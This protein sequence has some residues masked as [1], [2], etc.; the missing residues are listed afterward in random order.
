MN[1][2]LNDGKKPNKRYEK[3]TEKHHSESDCELINCLPEDV[4][5]HRSGKKIFDKLGRFIIKN[6]EF[7]NQNTN[8]EN[9]L[10]A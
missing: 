2:P 4:L 7:F 6:K 9:N 5:H 10:L 1:A 8:C 3:L